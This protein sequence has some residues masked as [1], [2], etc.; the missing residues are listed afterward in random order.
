MPLKPSILHYA[1]WYNTKYITMSSDN[2]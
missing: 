2:S 1:Q